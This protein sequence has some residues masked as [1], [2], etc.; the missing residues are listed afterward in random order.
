MITV[1]NIN[2][3]SRDAGSQRVIQVSP[4]LLEY[5]VER[6]AKRVDTFLTTDRIAITA[7][8]KRKLGEVA[9]AVEMETFP[10]VAEACAHGIRVVAI[11]AISDLVGEDL[12]LDFNRLLD[13]RG[14]VAVSRLV[15]KLAMRPHR[16]PALWRMGRESQRAAGALATFLDRYVR[17]LPKE[18]SSIFVEPAVEVVAR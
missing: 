14:R 8:E 12:P 16:L 4:D 2:K 18:R 1:V 6:G 9:D 13:E 17:N 11:R 15:G 5:A 7:E 10:I 3:R